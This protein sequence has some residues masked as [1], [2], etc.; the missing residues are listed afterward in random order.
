MF[1]IFVR[2]AEHAFPILFALTTCK[3]VSTPVLLSYLR[4]A[5][6]ATTAQLPD[7]SQPD[8][9]AAALIVYQMH[10]IDYLTSA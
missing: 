9:D 4:G 7:L 2:H 6:S 1:T 3:T 8:P 5:S 10:L